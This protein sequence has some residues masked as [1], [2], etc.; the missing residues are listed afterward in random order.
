MSK[1]EIYVQFL[2]GKEPKIYVNPININSLDGIVLKNPRLPLYAPKYQ[3]YPKDGKILVNKD[4]VSV[5]IG[6]YPVPNK[7]LSPVELQQEIS[8]L[9]R[10]LELSSRKCE[11]DLADKQNM[12]V[13]KYKKVC[14]INVLG[15]FI[16]LFL[17]L[18]LDEIKTIFGKL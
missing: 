3:W 14:N 5:E 6:R 4:K 1:K 8:Y 9:R 2:E 16:L 11:K 17:I 13:D 18:Y 10:D 7:I 12:L 15:F